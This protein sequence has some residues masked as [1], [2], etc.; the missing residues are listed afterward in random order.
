MNASNRGEYNDDWFRLIAGIRERFIDFIS[1][2]FSRD[3]YVVCKS[4]GTRPGCKE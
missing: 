3:L 1:R 4:T 2:F